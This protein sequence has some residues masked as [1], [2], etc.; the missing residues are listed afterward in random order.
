[1]DTYTISD[2][3]R[4]LQRHVKT[5][6]KLDRDGTLK[7]RRTATNRRYYTEDQLMLF[8]GRQT[9][10]AKPKRRIAYLRVSTAAQRSDLKNQR[11]AVEQYN[12]IHGTANVEYVEEIGG[13]LSFQRKRFRELMLAVESGEVQEIQVAHKDRLCRFGYD[14]F[15]WFCS[16]HGCTLTVLNQ[17][18]LSPDQEMVQDL[19]AIVHCF[20]FRFYGL[21]KYKAQLKDG[22]CDA[23][24]E[25]PDTSESDTG[26]GDLFP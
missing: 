24:T 9:E 10:A 17:E 5:L 25:S 19:L 16:R 15:E 12:R 6:Q 22:M 1:M 20:S 4:I 8:L 3:A 23:G 11:A 26:A 13:G 21:R 2:A 14:W 18:S 7:A